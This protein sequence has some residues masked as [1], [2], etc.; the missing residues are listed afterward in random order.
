MGTAPRTTG[1]LRSLAISFASAVFFVLIWSSG[2]LVGKIGMRE[3]APFTLL[4]WRFLLAIAVL[5]IVAIAMRAPWPRGMAWIHLLITGVLLQTVQMA[6]MYLGMKLGAS[7]GLSALVGSASPLV[8]AALAVPMFG[9][10][11][12]KSQW[13]GLVVGLLGVVFAVS[14]ELGAGVSIGGL[15]SVSAGLAGFVAGTLYQKRFGTKMDLRTGITVQLL[16]ALVTITPFAV[17]FGGLAI[18]VRFGTLWPIIWLAL[19][20]SIG[21][22][23]L[24]FVLLRHRGGGSATS[25]LFLVPP[26]T[27]LLAIPILGQPAHL[28]ALIGT[29]LAAAGVALVAGPQRLDVSGRQADSSRL[30]GG[31]SPGA[32]W[33]R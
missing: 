19:V 11:L 9:E 14:S 3:V 5:A 13:T 7:A 17:T 29:G 25:Y 22:F 12:R 20:C 4:W 15:I 28:G 30:M 1:R 26:A 6:G 27:S 8:I 21:G 32:L 31:P 24:L 33:R 10:R 18:P 23:A 16:G 2:Y